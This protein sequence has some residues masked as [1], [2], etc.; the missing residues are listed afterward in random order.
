MSKI[1]YAARTNA[2]LGPMG[3]LVS[4][5]GMVIVVRTLEPAL[6][7]EYVTFLALVTWLRLFGEAGGSIGFMRYLKSAEQTQSRGTFYLS[8]IGRYCFVG[9]VMVFALQYF[10]PLWAKWAGLSLVTWNPTVF[11]A[12]SLIVFVNLSG[13]IAYYG[14]LGTFNHEVALLSSH[15]FTILRTLSIA[16]VA[17]FMPTLIA[18]SVVLVLV[19]MVENVWY[20]IKAWS[21]FKSERSPLPK[22]IVMSSNNHGLV[23]VFDKVTS[24][25]GGGSF[26]LLIL[27]PVYGR[28]E[29]AFLA[30]ANDVIQKA[31]SIA[32]LPMSNMILPYLNNSLSNDEAFDAAAGKVTKLSMLLFLPVVGAVLIFVPSGL[33]LLFG[34][35]YR[36]AIPLA[37]LILIPAFF[38][39]WVR[40]VLVSSLITKGKYGQIIILNTVQAIL[41]I[42]AIYVTYKLGLIAIVIAQGLVKLVTGF[43]V[44]GLAYRAGIFSFDLIPQGLMRST[45]FAVASGI[46]IWLLTKH[47]GYWSVFFQ[48]GSYSLSLLLAL[49]LWLQLDKTMYELLYKLLGK[50]SPLLRFLLPVKC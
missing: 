44:I 46:C 40:F 36:D 32:G 42:L 5:F 33:P 25:M 12:V 28:H 43:G 35:I 6:Y 29:L 8:V 19:S 27:A 7:T 18:L 37:L 21:I 13:I 41:A 9:I 10:G 30:V 22:G 24:A 4:L 11:I 26:L 3:V 48:I 34:D 50:M 23:T 15:V 17:L 49:K 2:I 39:S 20:H 14:L 45:I 1:I 16:V 38:D 47:L 31:L